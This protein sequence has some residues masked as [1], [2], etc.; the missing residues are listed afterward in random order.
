VQTI[1]VGIDGSG[2]SSDALE[3]ARRLADTGTNLVLV[4]AY[5][6][7][8]ILAADGGAAYGRALRADAEATLAR[9]G[10]GIGNAS[11]AVADHHPARALQRIA[12]ERE[13]SLIVVGSSH[14]GALNRLLP[15]STG[16][17]LLRGAPCPVAIA[18]RRYCKWPGDGPRIV[19]C[20]Y[21][22][23]PDSLA[24]LPYA[25]RLA[26]RLGAGLRVVRVSDPPGPVDALLALDDVGA[27]AARRLRRQPVDELNRTVAELDPDVE[28]EA[29]LLCGGAAAELI[30][31]SFSVDFIVLGSR[32]YGP[33][34]G[35][36]VGSVSG[37][38]LRSAACPVIV[39]PRGV[40]ATVE[41]PPVRIA[42]RRRRT[43]SSSTSKPSI[44]R[45]RS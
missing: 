31:T 6:S 33:L 34:R 16:E 2:R 19:A 4:C 21:G 44:A 41:E 38:V 14:K 45:P 18:P 30:R 3:L 37:R 17:R 29:S 24:A 11:V 12:L 26:R 40:R 23:Q 8:P 43:A 36:L 27:A 1:V 22:T 39:V 5:P 15:G 28:A 10:S 7:D 13:A 9:F 35:A 20:A 42:A 32:G 25:A